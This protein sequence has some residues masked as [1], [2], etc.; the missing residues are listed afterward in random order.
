MDVEE[1]LRE[2]DDDLADF[3]LSQGGVSQDLVDYEEMTPVPSPA[4]P[5]PTGEDDARPGVPT[6][7]ATTG[8]ARP[9]AVCAAARGGTRRPPRA[10]I[11]RG[12]QAAIRVVRGSTQGPPRVRSGARGVWC[13]PPERCLGHVSRETPSM[14][15]QN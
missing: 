15:I 4:K 10:D 6:A 9:V 1:L 2:P 3:D 8:C 14:S 7:G 13:Y 11:A 12:V 5:K